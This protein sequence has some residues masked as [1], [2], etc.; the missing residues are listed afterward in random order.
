MGPGGFIASCG[1]VGECQQSKA[2]TLQ[3]VEIYE[4]ITPLW[5]EARHRENGLCIL[6]HLGDGG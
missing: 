4:D 6:R 3:R 2:V 5:D 1:F